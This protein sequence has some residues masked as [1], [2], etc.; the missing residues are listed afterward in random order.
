MK[1]VV[2]AIVAILTLLSPTRAA[3]RELTLSATSPFID[4]TIDGQAVRLRVDPAANTYITLDRSVA[5]RLGFLKFGR[6]LETMGG[7]REGGERTYD[8]G[9]VRLHGRWSGERLRIDGQDS[10]VRVDWYDRDEDDGA[11]GIISPSLLPYGIVRLVQHPAT[12]RE[13]AVS[14]PLVSQN[15][16]GRFAVQMVGPHAIDVELA[17]FRSRT[18]ATATAGSF[19]G[20]AYR[21]A[22]VGSEEN[23][24]L[25]LGVARPARTLQLAE[26]FPVAGFKLDRILVRTSDWRGKNMLPPDAGQSPGEIVVTSNKERQRAWAKLTLA[27]DV[28][29]P[30]SE[31]TYRRDPPSFILKC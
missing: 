2:T 18:V 8:I 9:R 12:G 7:S 19:I 17:P 25:A 23:I 13:Q 5:R 24:V 14:L 27:K 16:S 20:E 4:A 10:S 6:Q 15:R 26:P 31:I 28:L 1:F 30:C 3:E 21:G 11:D 22:M 29:G